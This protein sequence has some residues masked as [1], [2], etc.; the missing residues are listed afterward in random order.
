MTILQFNLFY[1]FENAESFKDCTGCYCASAFLFIFK[2]CMYICTLVLVVSAS[3]QILA[4]TWCSLSGRPL[5]HSYPRGAFSGRRYRRVSSQVC[6]CVCAC[7]C[8]PSCLAC[9]RISESCHAWLNTVPWV[10][11]CRCLHGMSSQNR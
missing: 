1:V 5:A 9:L 3:T 10:I 2:S 6:G 8:V 4:S 7:V 11:N